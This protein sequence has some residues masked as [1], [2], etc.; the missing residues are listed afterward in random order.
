M[1]NTCQSKMITEKS[2]GNKAG[3]CISRLDLHN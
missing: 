1:A 3:Y 2:D